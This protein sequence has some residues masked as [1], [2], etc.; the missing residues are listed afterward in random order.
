MDVPKGDEAK[1]LKVLAADEDQEALEETAA[2]LRELGHEVTACAVRP[3]EAADEIAR[4][5]PDIAVVI[6]HDDDEHALDLIAEIGEFA[7]GPVIALL[8]TEDPEFIRDA[9]ERGIFAYARPITT[10][11]VQSA[12]EVAMRRH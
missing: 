7:S 9:A 4:E 1:A 6:V 5:D 3:S 10:A 2:I 12:F 11:A 8:E